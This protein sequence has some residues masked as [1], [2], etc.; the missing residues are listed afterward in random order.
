MRLPAFDPRIVLTAEAGLASFKADPVA[1]FRFKSDAQRRFA[2]CLTKF[3]EVYLRSGN[4]AGKTTVGAFC[5][6]AL[7]RGFSD[8]DGVPLPLLGTPNTGV[9]L[10]KGR[11][12]AK[13]SVIRK[14]QE[15]IGDWPHHI[16]R[17]GAAI[18]AIWVKP[19][20][21]KEENW[22]NWSCIRFFV[23]GGQSVAGMR[24]DWAHA[25]EPPDWDMWVELR[26]RGKAN[27]HFVRFITAT[28]IDKREWRPLRDDFRGCAFPEGRDGKVELTMTVFDNEALSHEHKKAIEQDAKGP[29]QRAKLYGE[30]V[31]LAGTNPFDQEGLRRWSE[32]A[33]AGRKEVWT[34]RSGLTVEYEVWADP[35]PQETYFVIADPSAGIWDEAGLHDPCEVVVVG[36]R[37]RTI[38]A[39]FNGYIPAFELGRFSRMLAERYNRAMLVWER[40]SGYGEAFYEGCD[41]YGNVYIEHHR[42]SLHVPLSQRLGWLTTATTRGTIIG[43]LQRAIIEDGLFFYSREGCES[44][45]DV[46]VDRNG[47]IEAGA[48]SHDEDMIVLGLACH[49]LETLPVS[50]APVP[51]GKTDGEAFLE[52]NGLRV[53]TDSTFVDPFSI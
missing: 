11:A 18:E 44:L 27:R 4:Q 38:A 3:R 32:R 10:A 9:V 43:A 19:N 39:R 33:V 14:Y 48:G 7:A 41:R 31:D 28:P 51:V 15:A 2:G 46:V 21:S 34:T 42:D 52:R 47:R 37:S 40:N 45:A 26:M 8:L 25:D 1:H 24:L 17:N 50:Q 36:R 53:P 6:I 5:G 29:L 49:L 12:M 13:E 30:Y 23:E 22:R 35:T 16:E 20:R